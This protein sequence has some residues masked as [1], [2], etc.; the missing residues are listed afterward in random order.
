[1]SM[2]VSLIA[3]VATVAGTLYGLVYLE[4]TQPLAEKPSIALRVWS[5]DLPT[6]DL[7]KALAEAEAQAAALRASN[8]AAQ[9]AIA[10]HRKAG[11]DMARHLQQLEERVALKQAGEWGGAAQPTSQP[12][13]QTPGQAPSQ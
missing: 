4:R 3:A 5:G 1:M 9:Q 7:D 12:H 6:A 11:E 10:A 13:A 2:K 8:Q